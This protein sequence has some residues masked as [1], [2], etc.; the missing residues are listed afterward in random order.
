MAIL[1]DE[2]RRKLA[3]I[4]Q[5]MDGDVKLV[6]FTQ[7]FEC[8][9]CGVTRQLL[10]ELE[11]ISDKIHL[12]VYDFQKDKDKADS[13]GIDKIP[14]I[15]VTGREDYGIRYFGVP[16]GYEFSS[17][18]E[19]IL[20]VSKGSSNLSDDTKEKIGGITEPVHIQ[21]FV[22]QT[23][24]YCPVAVRMAHRLAMES[25]NIRGDMVG[26][27]EFPHLANKYRV[28][29]VPKVIINDRVEFEGALPEP[30]FVEKVLEA[31][32]K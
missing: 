5:D 17:L 8:E 7:E 31:V 25:G 21:V 22:T 20:D 12:E 16:S 24:P 9:F 30:L 28:F 26:A 11:S 1:K 14:A 29:G 15:A 2:D 13:Y 19:D 32:G 10:E 23:C 4:F 6:F 18:I 27:I 3:E